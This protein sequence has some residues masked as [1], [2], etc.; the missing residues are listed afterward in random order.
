MG[1]DVYVLV[2]RIRYTLLFVLLAVNYLGRT[3]SR[4]DDHLI[5]VEIEETGELMQFVKTPDLYEERWDTLPQPN[6]WRVVMNMPPDSAILNVRDTREILEIQWIDDWNK[7]TEDEKEAYRDTL[8][9]RHG[10]APDTRIFMTTGKSDFF[11]FDKVFPSISRGIDV[12]IQNDT[13]PW[14]AQSILMIESPGKLAYSNAG[15]LGP[16]QL[17]KTV[18]RNHGLVVNKYVDERKD[19]DK[20]AYGSAHLIRTACVPEA[21]RILRKFGINVKAEDEYKLWFRLTVLHLYH[22]GAGNV[23]KLLVNVVKPKSGGMH[24]IDKIWHSEY[25][26]FGNS[27]QNYSQLALA[28]ILTLDELI[29]AKCRSMEECSYP[30]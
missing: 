12:F 16:F 1:I 18:A 6:F 2:M 30:Y 17:M 23:D 25:G 27:S 20:S 28:S 15:A 8:R 26:N 3:Q 5:E 21:K 7:Q 13:D 19:F 14:Y 24:L 4:F 10:L 11:Q 9:K 29:H 22:A